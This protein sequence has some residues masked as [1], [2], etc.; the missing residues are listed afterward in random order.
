M[1]A[2]PKPHFGFC[3]IPKVRKK[4]TKEKIYN[5]IRSVLLTS[6]TINQCPCNK[7]GNNLVKVFELNIPLTPNQDIMLGYIHMHKLY[8]TY[9]I[10]GKIKI[11]KIE[12]F[13]KKSG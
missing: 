4:H 7:R 8:T 2:N 5:I 9:D 11:L 1:S 13:K 10:S 12:K 6:P 3:L